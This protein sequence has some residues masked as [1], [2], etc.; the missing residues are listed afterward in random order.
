V[1]PQAVGPIHQLAFT[2]DEEAALL[3]VAL[4]VERGATPAEAAD[5]LTLWRHLRHGDIV[6]LGGDAA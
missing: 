2:V 3:L 6:R 4:A 5:A 1:T